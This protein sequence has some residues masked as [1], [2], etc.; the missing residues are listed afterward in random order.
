MALESFAV[1]FLVVYFTFSYYMS[2][3][4]YCCATRA[5]ICSHVLLL[6]TTGVSNIFYL[7]GPG[8]PHE[9]AV[10]AFSRSPLG[11]ADTFSFQYIPSNPYICECF[12]SFTLFLSACLCLSSILFFTSILRP[13]NFCVDSTSSSPP[14]ISFHIFST[15]LSHLIR[16]RPYVLFSRTAS[17]TMAGNLFSGIFFT[18]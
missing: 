3:T 15:T 18:L 6:P 12:S 14:P 4:L 5:H 13:P 2:P 17:S 16:A 10:S 9:I 7:V 8:P 1:P 11:R